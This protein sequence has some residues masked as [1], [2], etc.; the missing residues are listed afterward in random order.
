MKEVKSQRLEIL[1]QTRNISG[2]VTSKEDN[3]GLP[4]VNVVEKGTS[5]GTV[6]NV[7]GEYSLEVS[8]G[9]TIEAEDLTADVIHTE[10]MKE[11]FFEGDR[12][13]YLQSQKVDIPNGDRGE[14]SIPYNDP[15]LYY[16]LPDAELDR[17]QGII[18]G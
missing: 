17:N 5:N 16:N 8:E 9:A 3:E 13:W 18:G 6:T 14:G 4:G 15:G 1:I 10:R 7:Q 2:T 12:L 11:M